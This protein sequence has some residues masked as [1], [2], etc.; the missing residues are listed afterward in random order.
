MTA[1]TAMPPV[2]LHP[3]ADRHGVPSALL[4]DADRLQADALPA[5]MLQ[6]LASGSMSCYY[7]ASQAEAVN[8]LLDEA[9]WRPLPADKIHHSDVALAE[10]PHDAAWIE[11]DWFLAPPPKPVGSQA[12][13]RALALKLV[14]LVSADA[15]THEIEALLRQDP[16]LSYH[17][18]R[19]V[20]SLGMGTG[21]RVTSFSQ[22][23]LILG[24]SQLR[25]WLN[26]MLFSSREADQRSAMLLARVSVRARAM[27][28]LAKAAGHDKPRQ[29]Q[30][31]M[32]GMFSLLGVLFGMPLVE[33]LKP[34][35]ISE[36]VQ[37]ALLAREGEL[38]QLLDVV[39]A[40]EHDDLAALTQGL[41]ALQIDGA[42]FN[43]IQAEA[44]LWMQGVAAGKAGNPHA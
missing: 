9:G 36:A 17:L 35:T 23:I 5:G 1:S 2:F 27:E 34:L 43:Q 42:S 20:N 7:R 32:A 13:S 4:I 30:A 6:E 22:A 33:V 37:Q 18:L 24:R 39:E 11:G 41:Q 3:L 16:T 26:L 12:A 8:Q 40:A 44:Y 19:L 14:Q 29:E 38:G 10:L 15:D 28:L 25:R 31:F 21:R